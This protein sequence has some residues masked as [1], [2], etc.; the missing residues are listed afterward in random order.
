VRDSLVHNNTAVQSGGGLMLGGALGHTFTNV[1]ISGNSAGDWA[2]G[3][4]VPDYPAALRHVTLYGNSAPLGANLYT[5]RTTVTFHRYAILG[6]PQGGGANC[7]ADQDT[8]P[9]AISGG[10]NVASDDSCS[11]NQCR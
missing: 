8:A 5:L 11:L 4:Y 6:N 2:G 7:S 9:P 3:L 1:T 10:Y